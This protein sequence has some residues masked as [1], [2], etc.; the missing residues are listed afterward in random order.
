MKKEIRISQKFEL[1]IKIIIL[2]S[3]PFLSVIMAKGN[4]YNNNIKQYICVGILS[5]IVMIFILKKFKIDKIKSKIL[6]IS[7]LISLY[8]MKYFIEFS[9]SKIIRKLNKTCFKTHSK[10]I[11]YIM[12]IL[13]IPTLIFFVYLFT[14]YIVPKIVKFIKELTKNEKKYL[15]I[16]LVIGGIT[17]IILSSLTTAFTTPLVKN[18]GIYYDVVYTSDSYSIVKEDAFMNAANPENDIRQPLFGVFA[19]PFGLIARII[20]EFIIFLPQNLS[21]G[22]AMMFIQFMIVGFTNIMIVRLLNLKEKDKKYLYLLFSISFPYLIFTIVVEQYVV[23]LFYLILSLYIYNCSNKTNYSYIASVGTLLTSGVILPA[24]SHEKKIKKI[25]SDIWKTFILF[26]TTTIIS[27]QIIQVMY[28][29]K[30]INHLMSFSGGVTLNIRFYQFTNF[31]SSLFF[32]TKGEIKNI[33]H[34]SYQLTK[35]SSINII[36]IL[37][38]ILIAISFVL[39]RKNKMAIISFLWV[40]FSI[41]LLGII[42]WGTT[43]NGLILYSLYFAWAYLILFYL[44]IKKIFKKENLFKIVYYVSITII[45]IFSIKEFIRIILMAVKYY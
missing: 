35:P 20:S 2:L 16:L 28:I 21:Y 8:I 7:T 27:G 11:V 37:M 33:G 39:N 34:M 24:I 36:G 18:R 30:T 10:N 5:F 26:I 25:I 31:V 44:F 45:A 17:T 41:I 32:G 23:A 29:N 6:I 15:L 3:A 1:I 19:L 43:E 14:K 38:F 40:I 42:G 9:S 22:T 13:A 12:A 4:I